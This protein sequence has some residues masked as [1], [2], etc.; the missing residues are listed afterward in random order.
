M[1]CSK[2]NEE[3]LWGGEHDYQDYDL[4]GDGIV[5]NYS[6]TNEECDVDMVLIYTE[7]K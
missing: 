7:N 6:C 1:I 5:S 2:C 4:E 3:L